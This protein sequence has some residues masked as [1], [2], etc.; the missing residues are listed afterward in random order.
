M[1][2]ETRIAAQLEAVCA[3]GVIRDYEIIILDDGYR[4]RVLPTHALSDEAWIKGL[5]T[6]A[7]AGLVLDSQIVVSD[8]TGDHR[9][10]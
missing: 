10:D 3:S 2:I 1:S 6:D 4:V 9:D 5:V 8:G 7:L